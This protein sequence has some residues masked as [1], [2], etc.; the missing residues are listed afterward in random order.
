MVLYVINL[1]IYCHECKKYTQIIEPSLIRRF[2]MQTFAIVTVC[3]KYNNT[4][5][6]LMSNYLYE[7]FPFY[8]FNLKLSKIY[9]NEMTDNYGIK[10]KIEKDLFYLINEPLSRSY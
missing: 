6:C 2:N 8:Y 1:K 10:H 4:K 9:I 5:Q 3:Q 7:K